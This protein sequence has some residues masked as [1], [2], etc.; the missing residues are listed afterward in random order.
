MCAIEQAHRVLSL[1]R[2]CDDLV[3][4]RE[5]MLGELC[6][7][8]GVGRAPLGRSKIASRSTTFRTLR[9]TGMTDVR[10]FHRRPGRAG[11]AAAFGCN[12]RAPARRRAWIRL[13]DAIRD[14]PAGAWTTTAPLWPDR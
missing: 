12:R 3:A 10:A 7:F 2:A 11:L 6:G 13:F 8:L 9:E 14:A 4:P 5:R 1:R